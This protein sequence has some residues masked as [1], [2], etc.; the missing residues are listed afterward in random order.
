[1]G[2][3]NYKKE[4]TGSAVGALESI[5]AASELS[6]AKQAGE[7]KGSAVDTIVV[8]E[9]NVVKINTEIGGIST[10]SATLLNCLASTWEEFEANINAAWQK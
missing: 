3:V 8:L 9:E 2:N 6:V 10:D 4:N 5:A 7:S 1:M